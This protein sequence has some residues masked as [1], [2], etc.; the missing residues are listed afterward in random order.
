MHTY[1]NWLTVV[2]FAGLTV[3]PGSAQTPLDVKVG[4]WQTTVVREGGAAAA[5]AIPQAVL[6]KMSPEQ[7]AMIEQRIKAASGGS[8]GTTAKSCVSRD[9]LTKGW[10]PDESSRKSCKYTLVSSTRTRQEVKTDCDRNGMKSTGT[11]TIEVVDSGNMKGSMQIVAS[12]RGG[13]PMNVNMIFTSKWV[14]PTCSE[15]SE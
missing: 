10:D 3:I 2:L 7:R 4:E 14:G 5:P 1:K 9:T 12:G 11:M 8:G 15:K 6:D 13:Q